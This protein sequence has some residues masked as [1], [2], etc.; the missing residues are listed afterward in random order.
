MTIQI[1]W[2]AVAKELRCALF[3]L[4]IAMLI[5]APV[6]ADSGLRLPYPNEFGEISAGTFD[7]G[8]HRVGDALLLI[9]KLDNGNVRMTAETEVESDGRTVASAVLAPTTDKL[10]LQPITQQSRSFD[11]D[12]NLLGIMI[13]DHR[14][15][16]AECAYPNESGDG[17]RTEKIS[18]P[19]DDRVVN[20]PLNLLFDPLVKGDSKTVDFQILLCRDGA[21]LL[22]FKAKVAR[23]D[24]GSNGDDPLVEI[25]YAPDQGTIL[26]FLTR[27]FIP[28]LSFWFDPASPE[29]WLA[30]RMPLYANGPEVYVVRQGITTKSLID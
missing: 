12:G 13:I 3:A 26:S 27:T 20:V 8:Q 11:H 2:T 16:E 7:V 22:D 15:A 4:A 23:R 6:H 1:Q 25:S 17:V 9:E 14:A 29:S 18:L 24:S 5:G 28:K 10:L 30:H 19:Q 21:R